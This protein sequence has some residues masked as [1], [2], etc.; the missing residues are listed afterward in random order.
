MNLQLNLPRSTLFCAIVGPTASG[1]SDVAMELAQM[2][3]CDIISVDSMQVY[4]G[5]DVGTAKPTVIDLEKVQHHGINVVEPTEWFSAERYSILI[6]PVLE[7]ALEQNQPLILSGGTGLYYR[8]LLEGFVNTPDPDEELR[9]KLYQQAE[10][11]GNQ[12]LYEELQR[13]DAETALAIHPNDTKRVVRALEI[14]YQTG[15]TL[16][17]LRQEQEQKPWMKHTKFIGMN[18]D[19]DQ[20]YDRITKRTLWMYENGLAKETSWMLQQGCNESHLAMKALGY[21][22][23]AR[24]LKGVCSL[25]EAVQETVLNT[26]HYAK[27]Q[28]TWFRHQCPVHW[29]DCV[30]DKETKEIAEECLQIW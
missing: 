7:D 30:P 21:N 17:E 3:H 8:A 1:K 20:L 4:K 25:D 28:M 18:W 5:L 12:S 23:C 24:S 15:K 6:E 29:L 2:L 11:K 19:R 13:R 14:P 16:S 9:E 26:R 10:E 22:E 27:R